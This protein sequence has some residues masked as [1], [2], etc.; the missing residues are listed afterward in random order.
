[1]VSLKDVKETFLG[2]PEG[3]MVVNRLLT[4]DFGEIRISKLREVDL[5]ELREKYEVEIV[6]IGN[7]LFI[8]PKLLREFKVQLVGDEKLTK[9][10]EEWFDANFVPLMKELLP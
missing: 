7:K 10:L 4:V 9:R 5:D 8:R 2:K 6:D 3:A 1:M